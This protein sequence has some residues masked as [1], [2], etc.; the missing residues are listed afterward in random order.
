MHPTGGSLRVFRQS[1]RLEVGSAKSGFSGL[2][3]QRVTQTVGPS[4]RSITIKPLLECYNVHSVVEILS[5]HAKQ[6]ATDLLSVCC[7]G[8]Y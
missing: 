8:W 4:K 7:T 5:A 2:A 6:P 1:A 3:H